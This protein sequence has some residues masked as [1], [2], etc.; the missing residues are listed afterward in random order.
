M[1][2]L[3]ILLSVSCLEQYEPEESHVGGDNVST[4]PLFWT[5]TIS[6]MNAGEGATPETIE[7]SIAEIIESKVSVRSD[8]LLCSHCHS[9][10][11]SVA[12]QPPT[13]NVDFQIDPDTEVDGRTWAGPDGWAERFISRDSRVGFQKPLYLRALFRKWV[14][15]GELK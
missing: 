3:L 2:V 10:G 7:T 6:S 8:K 14:N 13:G 5:S 9:P 11:S 15:D 1:T 12:Y 4:S